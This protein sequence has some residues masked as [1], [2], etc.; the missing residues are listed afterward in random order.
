MVVYGLAGIPGLI[1]TLNFYNRLGAVGETLREE[2][3]LSETE[4]AQRTTLAGVL[5]SFRGTFLNESS[6]K[7]M[8]S[9]EAKVRQDGKL[10]SPE[11]RLSARRNLSAHLSFD[12]G[13]SLSM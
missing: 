11:G 10:I 13:A 12:C 3:K 5:A 1:N 7:M 8:S 9:C 6:K 4:S 2:W